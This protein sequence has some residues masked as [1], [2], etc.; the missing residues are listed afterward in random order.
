MI[1]FDLHIR[2]YRPL[3]QVFTFVATPEND[4]QWQ[5]GTLASVQI[6]KGEVRVGTLFHTVGHLM[7]RRI[8]TIYEVTE[9]EPNERY[10]FKS[11]SGPMDLH[12]LYEFEM[13]EGA[14]TINLSTEIDPGDL[15]KTNDS[16]LEKKFKKQYK[17]NLA[18]LKSVLEADRIVV[19]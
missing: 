7:G 4:F 10:G 12:T 17:E 14:T 5:Y 16:M 19:S 8:E 18:I 2:V 9:F 6:T 3:K 1:N 13:T 11:H 15:F